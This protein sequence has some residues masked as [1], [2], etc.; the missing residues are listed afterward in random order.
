LAALTRASLTEQFRL[1]FQRM[2]GDDDTPQ[3]WQGRIEVR[4]WTSFYAGL[5]VLWRAVLTIEHKGYDGFKGQSVLQDALQ[6]AYEI[7]SR[8]PGGAPRRPNLSAN[9]FDGLIGESITYLEDLF[10]AA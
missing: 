5:A 2:L 4:D 10:P 6:K 7:Q 3:G 1:G 8:M 9:S